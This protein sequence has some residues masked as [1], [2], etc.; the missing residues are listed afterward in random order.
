[1]TTITFNSGKALSAKHE[2]LANVIL[3]GPYGRMSFVN[4]LV[5]IGADYVMFPLLAA[6]RVG[7]ST[8]S[9][10]KIYV[11]TP[12]G[13]MLMYLAY[14]VDIEVESEPITIDV[15]FNPKLKSRHL[16]GRNGM[17]ALGD[18]GFDVLDWLWNVS[19]GK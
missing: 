6:K 12:N 16:L 7:I 15:L 1:M 14:N 4:T 9:A 10:K 17:R 8:A 5:D 2:G 3:I 13:S 11:S 18:I 19:K